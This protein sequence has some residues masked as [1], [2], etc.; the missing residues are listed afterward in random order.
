MTIEQIA[1]RL[2]ELCR[3]G[4]F[5][6]AQKELFA[7][8]AISIEPYETPNFKKEVKGLP[9]ILEKGKKFEDMVETI[10]KMEV[11]EPLLAT[12]AFACTMR[13]DM[14]MKDKQHWDMTELCAYTVKDGKIA[15][16]QFFV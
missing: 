8:D 10:H 3:K 1:N 12:S 16:E 15:S 6:T 13:M 2:V 9:A 5:E 14:T 11:S 7:D 4:D